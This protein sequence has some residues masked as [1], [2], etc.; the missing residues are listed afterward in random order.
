MCTMVTLA[1]GCSDAVDPH[2]D[3]QGAASQTPLIFDVYF[4]EFQLQIEGA[5]SDVPDQLW[6]ST[7][8][9]KVSA[10]GNGE[11]VVSWGL[12][13]SYDN[14][15]LPENVRL[16]PWPFCGDDALFYRQ[17]PCA[18]PC[19]HVNYRLSDVDQDLPQY[20][21]R[22]LVAELS[23][24]WNSEDADSTNRLTATL[25]VMLENTGASFFEKTRDVTRSGMLDLL[26][27]L[28]AETPWRPC[29]WPELEQLFAT[30][31]TSCGG[32]LP[33]LEGNVQVHYDAHCGPNPP[34]HPGATLPCEE[35]SLGV[36]IIF[37]GVHLRPRTGD[38]NSCVPYTVRMSAKTT[39]AQDTA[40]PTFASAPAELRTVTSYPSGQEPC[41]AGQGPQC[42]WFIGDQTNSYGELDLRCVDSR[43]Q[44][45]RR[46]IGKDKICS[47]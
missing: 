22:L 10:K 8:P 24:P 5:Q 1:C 30:T 21:A 34:T 47:P 38:I 12:A 19:Y 33:P 23:A 27:V 14:P 3:A 31:L 2:M 46:G 36:D 41:D 39:L 40:R 35:K 45:F 16:S 7:S 37:S 9:M 6:W 28:L 13:P 25:P 11:V 26:N 43:W 20:P 17:Q 32:R 42:V 15:K 18:G 4:N 29:P 44:V